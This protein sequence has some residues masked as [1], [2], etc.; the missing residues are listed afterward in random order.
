MQLPKLPGL[1]ALGSDFLQRY[2]QMV[3]ENEWPAAGPLVVMYRE[4]GFNPKAQLTTTDTKTGER[5]RCLELDS[6]KNCA[7]GLLQWNRS[8][9][10]ASGLEGTRED[11]QRIARMSAVEQLDLVE[12]YFAASGR[13]YNN[14]AD[15][16]LATFGRADAIGQPN[17]LDRKSVV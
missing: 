2:V 11:L 16:Y 4:S 10:K 6:P 3:T 17:A 14:P 7:V 15:F 12:R 9:A 13:H 5:G 1:E 8:G